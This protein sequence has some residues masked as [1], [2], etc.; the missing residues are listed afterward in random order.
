MKRRKFKDLINHVRLL[1]GENIPYREFAQALSIQTSA[2]NQ[3]L[4]R[5]AYISDPEINIIREYFKIEGDLL[6]NSSKTV[7]INYYENP[8]LTS[9]IRNPMVEAFDLDL[10]LVKNIWHLEPENLRIIAMPGNKM[11]NNPTNLI[12]IKNRDILLMDVSLRDINMSGVYAYETL[13]GTCFQVSNVAVML[14]GNIRFYY[15]NPLY[16]DEVRTEQ[17]LR[18]LDFRVVGRIIKNLSFVS[19]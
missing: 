6:A 2:V 7:E 11:E 18:N 17:D 3:R 9:S 10:N 16:A 19:S 1:K 5:D 8:K 4:A 14:N 12:H 15:A 13:G